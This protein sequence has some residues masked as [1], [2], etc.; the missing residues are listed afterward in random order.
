MAKHP[1]TWARIIEMARARFLGNEPAAQA[2]VRDAYDAEE[3]A[4]YAA[5]QDAAD[6]R[7]RP[8]SRSG[9]VPR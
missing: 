3:T 7:P 1:N 2:F 4:A 9:T 5:A 8:C 6:G